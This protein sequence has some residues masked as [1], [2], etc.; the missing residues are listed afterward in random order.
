MRQI[1]EIREG[2]E[3]IP[4]PPPRHASVI[5][6]IGVSQHAKPPAVMQHEELRDELGRRMFPEIRRE[7]TERDAIT[8]PSDRRWV[9]AREMPRLY[10]VFRTLPLLF[11]R[12]LKCQEYERVRRCACAGT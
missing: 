3:R 9:S 2:V 12:G 7:V 6:A 10:P 5:L 1:F 4:Y 11:R 8:P